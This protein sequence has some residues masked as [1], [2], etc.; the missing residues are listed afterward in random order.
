MK[1]KETSKG[2]KIVI[3]I[4][5]LIALLPAIILISSVLF[6][7]VTIWGFLAIG[8]LIGGYIIPVRISRKNN[9]QLSSEEKDKYPLNKLFYIISGTCLSLFLVLLFL[10]KVIDLGRTLEDILVVILGGLFIISSLAWILTDLIRNDFPW[11]I[12]RVIG[13]LIR[14]IIVGCIVALISYLVQKYIGICALFFVLIFCFLVIFLA[15]QIINIFWPI[16]GPMLAIIAPILDI[17]DALN[18]PTYEDISFFKSDDKAKILKNGNVVKLRRIGD[19]NIFEDKD[20][21]KYKK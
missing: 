20:G 17:F 7:N 19:S 16:F 15:I 6:M 9:G 5:F 4:I 18:I 1:K 2:I 13:R 21:N 12:P 11:G 8:I 10:S 3:L 14:L